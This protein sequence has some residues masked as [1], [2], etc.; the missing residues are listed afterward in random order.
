[1]PSDPLLLRVPEAAARLGIGRST[2]YV[3]MASGDIASVQI[4]RSRRIRE[5]TLT[6]WVDRLPTGYVETDET[7]EPRIVRQLK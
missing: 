5:D 6:A 1:M 3:L 7:G 2:L 4:G